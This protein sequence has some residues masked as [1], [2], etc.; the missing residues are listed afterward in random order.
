MSNDLLTIPEI[1]IKLNIT[2]SYTRKLLRDKVIQ[3]VKLG[4]EW[5]VHRK[6]MNKYLGVNSDSKEVKQEVYIKELEGKINTLETKI[7]AFKSV[8]NSV[9]SIIGG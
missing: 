2:E 9:N 8:M 1:A 4:G 6:E 5:R 3:G 7:T